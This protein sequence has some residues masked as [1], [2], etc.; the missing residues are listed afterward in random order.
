MRYE[1]ATAPAPSVAI[2]RGS[3]IVFDRDI[4]V[5]REVVG[6]ATLGAPAEGLGLAFG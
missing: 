1:T 3:V 4:T 5:R 6:N 2:V